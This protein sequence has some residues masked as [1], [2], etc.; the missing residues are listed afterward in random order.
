MHTHVEILSMY[1]KECDVCQ[2]Y[3]LADIIDRTL[4]KIAQS[5]TPMFDNPEDNAAYEEDY[6]K[7]LDLQQLQEQGDDW[8]NKEYSSPIQDTNEHKKILSDIKNVLF[9]ILNVV[10]KYEVLQSDWVQH[11]LLTAYGEVHTGEMLV[12]MLSQIDNHAIDD[13]SSFIISGI[14]DTNLHQLNHVL[15]TIASTL[16]SVLDYIYKTD[17]GYETGY[18]SLLNK[19][20]DKIKMVPL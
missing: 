2:Y 16:E 4:S 20:I 12:D 8:L 9:Q 5:N 3:K 19:Y 14:K 1:S 11:G 18:A 6:Q 10:P 7:Y 13:N 17:F 15:H